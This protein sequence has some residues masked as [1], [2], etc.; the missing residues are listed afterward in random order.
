MASENVNVRV[1]GKLRSHLEQQISESG[2]YENASEYIRS[3]IRE[4]LMVNEQAW[5]YLKEKLE[6]GIRAADSEFTRVS[7]EEIITRS[8]DRYIS[9]ET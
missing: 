2:L 9:K 6:A 7:A 5:K 4:D 8:K 3:L 1:T